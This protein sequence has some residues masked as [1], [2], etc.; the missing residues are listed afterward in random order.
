MRITAHELL[1][2]G[3]IDQ[4]IAEPLPAHEDPRAAIQA[5]GDEIKRNLRELIATYPLNDDAAL[6]RLVVARYE[7]FRAIGSWQE[8]QAG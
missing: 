1:E 2:F 8:E 7:R 4:V 6:D 3:I 5:T